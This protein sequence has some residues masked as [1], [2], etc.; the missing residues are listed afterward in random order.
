MPTRVL[1]LVFCLPALVPFQGQGGRPPSRVESL[2]SPAQTP[3]AKE[4][5]TQ[6][7]AKIDESQ[8]NPNSP[9]PEPMTLALVGSGLIALALLSRKRQMRNLQHQG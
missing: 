3:S 1:G 7:P 4:V 5:R 2:P 6:E 9:V 8:E